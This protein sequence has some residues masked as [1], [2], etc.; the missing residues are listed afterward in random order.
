MHIMNKI[1]MSAGRFWQAFGAADIWQGIE[2]GNIKDTA[3]SILSLH[4]IT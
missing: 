1:I 4:Y 3:S 2:A